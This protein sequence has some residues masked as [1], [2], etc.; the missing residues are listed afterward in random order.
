[1][2]MVPETKHFPHELGKDGT[3]LLHLLKGIWGRTKEAR[4]ANAGFLMEVTQSYL[5]L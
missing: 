4:T 5:A 3:N 2:T 1:M